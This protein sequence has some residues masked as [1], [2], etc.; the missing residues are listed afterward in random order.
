MIGHAECGHLRRI[1]EISAVEYHRLAQCADDRLE[2]RAAELLPLGAD[3]LAIVTEW[4][5]FRSPDLDHIRATLGA[6]VIFDGR[7]LY[8]PAQMA[9]LGFSYYAVGRGLAVNLKENR[10]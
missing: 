2:V 4:Q 10:S 6:P 3:A 5:E 7:N 8:D 9:R 1:V